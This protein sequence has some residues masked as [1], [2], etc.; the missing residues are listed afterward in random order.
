M[1][2]TNPTREQ[3]PTPQG[4]PENSVTANELSLSIREDFPLEEQPHKKKIDLN[5]LFPDAETD[6]NDLF[7]DIEIKHLLK[8]ITK[9][10]KD[11][12]AIK[13]RL[14][15]ENETFGEDEGEELTDDDSSSSYEVED[16]KT[17]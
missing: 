17:I 6:L 5:E 3:N 14:T 9:N 2:D 12:S 16:N 4:V 7:P 8:S 15:N 11:M 10:K 13:E 1:N